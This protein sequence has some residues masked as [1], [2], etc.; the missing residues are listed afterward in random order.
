VQFGEHEARPAALRH[1][2]P[3]ESL[4]TP[5]LY[6]F[7]W[8]GPDQH[9]LCKLQLRGRRRQAP[10]SRRAAPGESHTAPLALLPILVPSAL[11]SS[12]KVSPKQG[13]PPPPPRRRI[14]SRP[15]KTLPIWSEPPIC[16]A[17]SGA[18][19]S[20]G[21]DQLKAIRPGPF[22][23]AIG[24]G[25]LLL[26]LLFAWQGRMEYVWKPAAM[27]VTGKAHSHFAVQARP[28][29]T[30]GHEAVTQRQ[31]ARLHAHAMRAAHVQEVVPLQQLVR[32]P[33]AARSH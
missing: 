11:V 1:A 10:R 21:A 15:V 7:R 13:A 20:R 6:V 8:R 18:R 16:A 5:L 22:V 12:G 4:I 33:G 28:P 30:N 32:E 25:P 27:G 26:T 31:A 24:L 9:Q 29:C 14:R 3:G 23:Q 2:A 17:G 19:M